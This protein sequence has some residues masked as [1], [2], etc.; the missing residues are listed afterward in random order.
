MAK[1]VNFI[2]NPASGFGATKRHLKA[3]TREIHAQRSDAK[4]SLTHHSLHAISLTKEAL[5][6]GYERIVVIGGDGTLNEVVNGFFDHKDRIINKD[7]T[8]ALVASGS[9]SDFIRSLGGKRSLSEAVDRALNG[10]VHA[11]D[12]GFVEAHDAN[13]ELVRRYFINVSSFGLSGMVA[14]NMRTISRRFGSTAAYFLSTT[15]A[16]RAFE[17]PVIA[18]SDHEGRE[19]TIERCSLVS[20]ANGRFYGSGMMIAPEAK[21]DDGLFDV[22]TI[23][24]LNVPFFLKNGYKVYQGKH[25]NLDNV[26]VSR[27]KSCTARSLDRRPVYIETDGELFAELPARYSIKAQAINLAY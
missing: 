21:I 5:E 14:G 20:V 9:G 27:V 2:I 24:D 26:S 7:A 22:V 1:L 17:A 4:I 23:K 13:K 8:L 19:K 15:K 3:I 25:L 18:L 11:C 6:K 16:I 12:L 10:A